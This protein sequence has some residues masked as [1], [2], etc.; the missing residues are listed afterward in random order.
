[1]KQNTCFKGDGG[2]CIDLLIANSKFSFMKKNLKNLFANLKKLQFFGKLSVYYNS[3]PFWKAYK[4][5]F[6]NRNRNIQEN[7][8]FLEKDKSLSKQK[9]AAAI[10]NKHFGSIKD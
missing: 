3:K 6:S 9:G 7:I 4:P 10:F 8:M 2:L 1:M 5:Y